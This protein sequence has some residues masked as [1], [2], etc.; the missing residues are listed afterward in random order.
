LD[1]DR[2]Q[3]FTIDYVYELP[4]FGGQSGVGKAI[5]NGWQLSGIT[6]FWT[7]TPLTI[8]SNGNLGTLAGAPRANFLGGDP[9]AGGRTRFQ[10]FDPLLFARPLDGQLGNTANG[11]LRGPGINNWD[12]SLFKT[13]QITERVRVQLRFEFFNLFNH[14]QFAGV[15]TGIGVPNPGQA[16]TAATR[17]RTGEVTSTRDAR[18]MQLGAKLY[19]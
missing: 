15:N 16:V 4:K 18:T 17:G 13:T 14:T 1:F 19:F 11:F 5:F 7:G 12:A 10:W 9:Y 3:I 6:R 8:N 2:T